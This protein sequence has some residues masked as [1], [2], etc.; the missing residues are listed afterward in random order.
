MLSDTARPNFISTGR[1][2]G[3]EVYYDVS[4]GLFELRLVILELITLCSAYQLVSNAYNM[5]ENADDPL[6]CA[7]EFGGADG[8]PE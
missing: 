6:R 3:K 5:E 1:P 4:G 7:Q 8:N 2:K